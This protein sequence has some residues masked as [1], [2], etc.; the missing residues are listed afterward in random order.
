MKI[1]LAVVALFCVLYVGVLSWLWWKQRT[2]LYPAPAQSAEAAIRPEAGNS[3]LRL[4]ADDGVELYAFYRPARPGWPTL[5]FFHGNGDS[6]AGSQQA[7]R[8]LATRGY[9]LLLPE[10]RGY[11]GNAGAPTERGLYRDGA[12]A[13]NWLTAHG[14]PG[15]KT[16]VI[17]NSLGSGVATEVAGAHPVGALVLISAF[18][19]MPAVVRDHLPFVPAGL[20]VTDR[21]DNLRKVATLSCPVLVLHGAADTVISVRHGQAL[22]RARCGATLAIVSDAGHELAYTEAAQTRIA[23][24]LD[25]I[26]F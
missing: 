4:K 10:Y 18:T 26:G 9:G 15:A 1:A 14:I 20:L 17:G 12:A 25:T 19:D 7:T 3:I 24:W 2:F 8:A 21:Y 11:G 16:I 6:L 23:T 5:L 22:A 13:L